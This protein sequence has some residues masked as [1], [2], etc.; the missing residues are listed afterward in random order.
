MKHTV[1]LLIH[2]YCPCI[3][4]LHQR[5]H[6]QA[7]HCVNFA[8]SVSPSCWHVNSQ[9]NLQHHRRM[10][11]LYASYKSMACLHLQHKKAH[12]I[13]ITATALMS[14]H[15]TYISKLFKC[16]FLVFVLGRS[17]FF[18]FLWQFFPSFLA[19]IDDMMSRSLPWVQWCGVVKSFNQVVVA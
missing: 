3:F 18:W 6:L 9:P 1:F 7:V 17:G 2:E 13:V 8:F 4:F 15:S 16:C 10:R 19:D 5:V 14:L 11:R 12:H